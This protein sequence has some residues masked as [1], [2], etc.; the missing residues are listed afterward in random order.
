M[1]RVA[2]FCGSSP[3]KSELY[4]EAARGMG[5]ALA[6]R[7]LGLVY[8]GGRVGL[9][10]AM[11]DAALAAGTT[12]HGVIPRRIASA[13]VAHSGVTELHVVETMHQ[14]KAMMTELADAFVAMPGGSGTLD[15]L[16]EAV[17]WGQ[18]GFHHKP[19]GLLDV[20]GFFEP[21]LAMMDRMVREGFVRPDQREALK[22]HADAGGL[23]DALR[24]CHV[25]R[26]R[27]QP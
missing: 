23:L 14:R 9:M 7:G 2:V 8:G 21:L 26:S 15:E 6:A 19:V 16:F 13:E 27:T 5:R 22:V 3:G 25:A 18:L 10:G 24:A 11:A 4:V 1:K 12:V 17:T 20:G